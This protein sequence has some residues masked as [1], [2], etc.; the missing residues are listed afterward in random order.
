[1]SAKF[2]PAAS[3]LL[4]RNIPMDIAIKTEH[5]GE[6]T[7]LKQ[8]TPVF[9]ALLV[10]DAEQKNFK[11]SPADC[12][13]WAMEATGLERGY[14]RHLIRIGRILL[15]VKESVFD[16]M[17]YLSFRKLLDILT[18]SKS[19]IPEFILSRG[20]KLIS[21]SDDEVR[22]EVY[23]IRGKEL[24]IHPSTRNKFQP[25]LWDS[26]DAICEQDEKDFQEA[27]MSKDFDQEKACKF[28]FSGLGLLDASTTYWQVKGGL[29]VEILTSIEKEL[30]QKADRLQNMRTEMTAQLQ[31]A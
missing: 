16:I 24:S 2:Y 1:M 28:A 5:I 8:L 7:R 18:L 20:K 21:M 29:D 22:K 31:T 17:K 3:D 15:S 14:L 19:D 9:T 26:I 25:S 4:E 27:A 11:D 6:L 12:L 30:R 10:A 13:S 23:E